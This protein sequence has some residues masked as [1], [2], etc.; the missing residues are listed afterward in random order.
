MLIPKLILLDLTSRLQNLPITI[1]TIKTADFN[2]V[3]MYQALAGELQMVLRKHTVFQTIHKQ[4]IT[5]VIENY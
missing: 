2:V 5:Y 1:N 4:N 3:Q